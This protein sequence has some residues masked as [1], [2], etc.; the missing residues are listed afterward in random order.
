MRK[1]SRR[2]IALAIACVALGTTYGWVSARANVNP[3]YEPGA[4]PAQL[5]AAWDWQ[6]S[7]WWLPSYLL[8]VVPR[9]GYGITHT[10]SG[11]GFHNASDRAKYSRASTALGA[12]FGAG[13]AAITL[14]LCRVRCRRQE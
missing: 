9:N 14:V 2:A 3:Y 4:P 11:Y 1:P 6:P 7:P 8:C 13:A 12:G 5:G 10:R